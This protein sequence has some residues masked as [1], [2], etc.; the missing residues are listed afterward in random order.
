M[1]DVLYQL[2]VTT[3][4]EF[5]SWVKFPQI[6]ADKVTHLG[7]YYIHFYIYIVSSTR[8]QKAAKNYENQRRT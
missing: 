7:Q 1:N 2:P 8:S 6:A 4:D 3:L 5:F